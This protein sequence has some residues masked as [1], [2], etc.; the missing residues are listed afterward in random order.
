MERLDFTAFYNYG[1][2]W[3]GDAPSTGR[4]ISAHG[5]NL[6]LQLENKGVRFNVGMGTGQ[7]FDYAWD[8]YA[9]AGFDA[10]F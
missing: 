5:Y 1:G 10:L 7:V 3:Y 4:L 2:A 6:D 9:T 8:I